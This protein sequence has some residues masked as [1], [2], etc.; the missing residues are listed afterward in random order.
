MT[1]D[2]KI[3]VHRNSD[4]L[5]VKL[6]GEF[7]GSSAHQLLNFLEKHCRKA[8]TVFINTNCLRDVVPFGRNIFQAN[9]APLQ[10][11]PVRFVFTGEKASLFS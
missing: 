6:L 5:H 9:L 1:S 8:S 2:F 3:L 10:R 11:K 4:N 7:D